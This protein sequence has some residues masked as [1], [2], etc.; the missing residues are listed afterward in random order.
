MSGDSQSRGVSRAS[1]TEESVKEQYDAF[2]YPV[3]DPDD[4]RRRLLK[5]ILDSLPAINHFVFGGQF[6]FSTVLRILVAGGGTGDTLIYLAQQ[7][8]D[9]GLRAEITYLDLSASARRVAEARAAVRGLKGIRFM[10]GSLLDLQGHQFDYIACT[11]V[12]HHL[13]EPLEGV[14]A[15]VRNLSARGGMGLMLYATL[16]R[17]GVYPMQSMLRTLAPERL[18]AKERIRI[19]RKLIADLPDNNWLKR[20]PALTK[21]EWREDADLYDLLLHSQDRAY[22]I[23]EADGLMN[24]AGLR[25]S[26]FMPPALFEPATYLKDPELLER[27]SE[28]E[29]ADRAAFAEKLIGT[30]N[31]LVFY[32][33]RA[34]NPV[35]LPDPTDL[36]FVP[37]LNSF[38]PLPEITGTDALGIQFN[39][40]YFHGTA[41]L[42][43]GT[44]R[45]LRLV[46]GQRTLDEIRGTIGMESGEFN[47]LVGSIYPWL[48]DYTYMQLSKT[49]WPAT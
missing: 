19:A 25:I 12:L 22:S 16:G 3:R 5:T 8:E 42:T 10:T 34:Q 15:L 13:K 29:G 31:K 26:S 38:P 24:A 47:R 2:P 4:E 49:P 21:E 40:P 41:R 45:V 7:V 14:K 28:L 6:D 27:I 46:N 1:S 33:V 11:G 43:S 9:L 35:C 44:V 23:E 20:N 18:P 37:N 30:L 32:C 39:G 17:T 36:D 48:R